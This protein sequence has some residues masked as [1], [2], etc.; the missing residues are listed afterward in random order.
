MTRFTKGTYTIE[1]TDGRLKDSRHFGTIDEIEMS[2]K[3]WPPGNYDVSLVLSGSNPPGT[4]SEPWATAMRRCGRAR[5]LRGPYSGRG[6]APIKAGPTK[7][8]FAVQ[9]VA[10]AESRTDQNQC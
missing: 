8:A 6:L 2:V 10:L 4:E 1:S 7:S 3:Q 5:D 9:T